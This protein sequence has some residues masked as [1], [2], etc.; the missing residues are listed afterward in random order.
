MSTPIQ[1]TSD[2]A[3][4]PYRIVATRP[5]HAAGVERVVRRAHGVGPGEACPSCFTAA[6]VREQIRRFPEGQFVA[7]SGDTEE[8]IGAATLMRTAHPPSSEPKPWL[9]MIGDLGLVNH[10]PDGAWLYG[11]EMVVDPRHQGRG[12]GSALYWRR[13]ALVGTLGVAGMYAGG[14]LK[15]YHRYRTRLSPREYAERVRRGEIDDPT[16]TMQINR[17]FRAGAIIENYDEDE[18]SD[19]CAIL[20]VWEADGQR[21]RIR[22]RAQSQRS[23]ARVGSGG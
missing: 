9:A 22:A 11:V 7:V 3:S 2:E 23:A 4:S 10:E 19:D 12:V 16:V 1:E 17:G 13:L 8:V 14:L 5:R 6:A 15:G 18:R 21:R 20:I